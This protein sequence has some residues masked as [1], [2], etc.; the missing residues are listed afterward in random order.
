MRRSR[1]GSAEGA[2][3]RRTWRR[4]VVVYLA[5]V[6]TVT[7]AP[8]PPEAAVKLSLSGFDKLVHAVVIAGLA[9]ILHWRPGAP[10]RLSSAIIA[11][12]AAG[13]VAGLIELL[14]EPLPYRSGDIW[15]LVAGV[16]G[17]LTAIVVS[18]VVQVA[19]ARRMN[20]RS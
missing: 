7:L 14:Q 19:T 6:F 20:R 12:L 5:V 8:I 3:A 9:L 1:F 11:L 4:L 16:G 2:S 17:A 13:F 10:S 15:D 18:S